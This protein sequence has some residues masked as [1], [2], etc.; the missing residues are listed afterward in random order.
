MGHYLP[1]SA[2]DVVVTSAGRPLRLAITPAQNPGMNRVTAPG[3]PRPR[4]AKEVRV[5]INL[6]TAGTPAADD[7]SALEPDSESAEP[8]DARLPG[9]ENG[10]AVDVGA[11]E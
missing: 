9:P 11:Q 5:D 4:T 1:T 6:E 7:A 10:S 3:S 2:S 8:E